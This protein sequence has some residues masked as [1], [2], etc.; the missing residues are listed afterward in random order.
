VRFSQDGEYLATGCNRVAQIFNVK[1]GSKTWYIYCTVWEAVAQGLHSI[2]VDESTSKTG[3]LYIRSVCFSPDGKQLATGAEDARIRVRLLRF[4]TRRLLTP[5]AQIWD[6]A[7]KRIARIYDGH[8]QDIYSLQYSR[9]GRFIVSGSGDGTVRVW[10]M[11]AEPGMPSALTRVLSIDEPDFDGGVT[12]VAISPDGRLVAAGSLDTAVRIWDV[13]TG[14][15][16]HKLLGHKNSVYSVI[17]NPDGSGL[18]SSSLDKTLKYWDVRALARREPGRNDGDE[19]ERI[20]CLMNLTGHKVRLDPCRATLC[21]TKADAPRRTLSSPPRF[22]TTVSGS[23]PAPRIAAS[24]SGTRTRPSCSA[25]SRATRTRARAPASAWCARGAD[26]VAWWQSS[27]STSAR[28]G[29][30]SRAGAA[31]APRAYVR[32]VSSRPPLL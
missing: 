23:S 24:N 9:D 3:D 27:R 26:W 12:S 29:T 20:P 7:K 1:N 30:S 18:I 19:N 13:G 2:L 16:L 28:R 5:P 17:F 8:A 21:L 15:L 14:V 6:I 31:T 32:P 10:G 22:R 11:T 4:T 25:C